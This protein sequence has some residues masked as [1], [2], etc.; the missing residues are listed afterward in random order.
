M[1]VEKVMIDLFGIGW[2]NA[3]RTY[4][5]SQDFAKLGHWLMAERKQK[6]VYPEQ[7]NVFKAFQLTP[8]E[9]VKVVFLGLDPYIRKDQ[10]TGLSFGV[11]LS[12]NMM[13]VPPSLKTIIKELEEDLDTLC[14]EFDYSLEGWAK[15]GVLM[16]NTSLT[17]V[18]GQTNSHLQMWQPFTLEV[19]DAINDMNQNVIFIL[20]GNTAQSY[21]KYL[22]P[23][24]T[25]IIKAPHPAAEAYAG[26]KAGFY[27]SKIFSKC[28]A[29]LYMLEKEEINWNIQ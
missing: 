28:N 22:D 16:L 12:E 3:M 23:E 25:R 17:V 5:Q 24:S 29:M 19:I 21:E 8:Y 2:Y 1:S 20:L 14:L 9:K 13:K 10:A 27:G 18:E 15:Q 7:K 11:E 26:G 4:L 6:T